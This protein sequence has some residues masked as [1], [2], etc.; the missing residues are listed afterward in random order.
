MKVK[1]LIISLQKHLNLDD[2]N[3]NIGLYV[4]SNNLWLDPE[5]LVSAYTGLEL[6][7]YIEYKDKDAPE[8]VVAPPPQSLA[9]QVAALQKEV[10]DYQRMLDEGSQF[11]KT[12]MEENEGLKEVCFCFFLFSL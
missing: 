4:K 12:T 5:S 2:Q 3:K 6:L 7:K 11:I 1:D 9:E 8:K 10:E